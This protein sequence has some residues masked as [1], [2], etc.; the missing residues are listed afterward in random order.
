MSINN[1]G[2]P[3]HRRGFLSAALAS[4]AA[5]VFA[6][7]S[8]AAATDDVVKTHMR[9][10]DPPSQPLDTMLLF[11]RGDENNDPARA[12]THQVLSL[13]HE[14]KGKHSYPWTMYASLATLAARCESMPVFQE[15]RLAFHPPGG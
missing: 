2:H 15:T 6:K 3:R 5:C 8:P 7:E 12:M 11:E 9:K 1:Q 14:E 10:G 13:I 4:L